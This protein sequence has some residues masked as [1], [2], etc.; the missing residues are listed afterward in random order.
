MPGSAAGPGRSATRLAQAMAQGVA[1][2]TLLIEDGDADAALV[3]AADA[4]L[5]GAVD[6]AAMLIGPACWP[7]AVARPAAAAM[8]ALAQHTVQ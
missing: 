6:G 7:P 5:D 1:G 4:Y 3:I 8:P 2:A